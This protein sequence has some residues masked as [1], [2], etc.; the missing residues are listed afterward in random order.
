MKLLNFTITLCTLVTSVGISAQVLAWPI[1][2]KNAGENVLYQ[3]QRYLEKELVRD[4]IFIGG[5][6]G[7]VVVCP[8]NGV[9]DFIAP[10]YSASLSTCS[11]YQ[12]DISKSMDE[13]LDNLEIE[14]GIDPQY[15][16]IGMMIRTGEGEKIHIHGL[17]GDKKFKTGQKLSAGDTLGVMGYSYK[18]VKSASICISLSDKKGQSIDPMTPFGLKTTFVEPKELTREN[19]T[20]VEKVR[21]D[22]EVLKQAMIELYPSLENHVSKEEWAMYID[23]IKQSV[24]EP[25][26]PQMG[27]RPILQKILH[28]TPDSHMWLLDDIIAPNRRT[29]WM[30][31]EVLSVCQDTVRIVG[32]TSGYEQYVGRV[33]TGING[34]PIKE[35]IEKY[36]ETRENASDEKIES[37]I[38]MMTAIMRPKGERDDEKAQDIL[39]LDDGTTVGFKYINAPIVMRNDTILNIIKWTQINMANDEDDVYE[40][41]EL[42]DSTSYLSIKTFNLPD[43]QTEE[44]GDYLG[45]CKNHLIIDLRNNS[46]GETTKMAKVLSY[47]C[48]KPMDRQKGGY[49]K[50]NKKGT[51][52]MLKYSLNYTNDMKLYED[53]EQREDGCYKRDS[54]ETNSVIMPD[55]TI[56]YKGN[57]YV[58]TNGYSGSASTVFPSVLV[59]NRRGVTVGRETQSTYHRMTCLDYADIKLPNTMQVIRIPMV[60]AVFDTTQC[61]RVPAG[62]GLIPDYPIPLTFRELVNGVDADKDVMLEYTLKLIKEGKYLSETNPFEAADRKYVEKKTPTGSMIAIICA[63]IASLGIGIG[64]MKKNRI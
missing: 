15:V 57:I 39:T 53:Y 52:D 38:E 34:K 42:N 49:L 25:I 29:K 5:N 50:V 61:T 48:D 16:T 1:A 36:K 22:L 37:T 14:K 44:I 4:H 63:I 59:R 8:V 55:T 40:T 28:K 62:R 24:T 41:R 2:G 13:N 31:S 23:S 12:Y 58:L 60:Q 19:P 35:V 33:V 47:L 43:R 64:I 56:N 11:M 10:Q 46:G 18:K 26:D 7:D 51:F 21:E 54:I 32:V 20:S 9:L 45:K 3:P 17:R 30:P 27:F 6:E